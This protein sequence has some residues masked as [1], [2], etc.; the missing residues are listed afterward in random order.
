MFK[1]IRMKIF[2]A[3]MLTTALP[4]AIT[5]GIILYQVSQDMK[6]DTDFARSR[7]EL[8]L[9]QRINE[10]SLALNETAYQIYSNSDLIESIALKKEFLSDSRTYD[11]VR[12]IHEYFLSVYNQSR[13]KDILGMYLIRSDEEVLGNFFPK[14]YPDMDT[15]YYRSLLL[16]SKQAGDK[17][18]TL[19][20]YT[21]LYNEPI[22]QYLYPVRY[23]GKP[24]GLLVIDMKEQSFRNLVEA[25]NNLYKGEFVVTDA[26]GYAVYHTDPEK[27]GV[28]YDIQT[29]VRS[30]KQVA[31]D[32]GDSDW[33]LSYS[34]ERN[35]QQ[36]LYRNVAIL[37]II[38]TAIL[39]IAISLWLSYSM[40]KPIIHMHRKMV[41]IQIG[42]YDARVDVM[43]SDEIGYLGHQFNRMAEKIQQLIEHDLK[44]QLTNQE[45]QIKAL[46]AQISPHFLFNTLQMMAGIA[47]VKN[48]PDLKLICRS[49]SNMYRYNMNIQNEWVPVR[50]EIMHIRNYLVIINKRFQGN[51]HTRIIVS[52]EIATI[53]IPKL[54][55]QPIVENA[56]EHGLIP[57]HNERQLLKLSARIDRDEGALYIYVLDNGVGM[58]E[59]EKRGLSDL[60]GPQSQLQLQQPAQSD[61]KES[62]IGLVNVHSRIRLICGEDYGISIRS[63]KGTGTCVIFRLP[64]KEG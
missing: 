25:Y 3:L 50:D 37:T 52:P 17:P 19:I 36:M 49:L 64:W 29:G 51:I 61:R 14:L 35:P 62:S 15:A 7:V 57:C 2:L 8:D 22:I 47:E 39:A 13:V 9:K 4:L 41:R 32:L 34:F 43:T 6:K 28:K 60:L 10:Y 16:L 40:T 11:S 59:L 1:R 42:D 58:G 5:S 56:V 54:I 30:N 45:T 48:V 55:L 38:G 24:S 26:S 46:Q 21:S 31:T 27:T 18:K 63:K 44:L 20:R 12:D 33:K 23:R 53:P